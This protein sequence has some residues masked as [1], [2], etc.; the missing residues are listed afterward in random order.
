MEMEPARPRKRFDYG[1]GQKKGNS[2]RGPEIRTE[3]IS[4]VQME[5]RNVRRKHCLGSKILQRK[6]NG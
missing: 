5:K 3:I 2:E 6:Q 4:N 1:T